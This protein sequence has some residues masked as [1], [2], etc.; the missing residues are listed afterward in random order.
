MPQHESPPIP[1]AD[2]GDSRSRAQ[3]RLIVAVVAHRVGAV[4]IEIGQAGVEVD[5]QFPAKTLLQ[6]RH[7]FRP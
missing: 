7:G 1:K 5:I 6:A 4:P 3:F 2:R